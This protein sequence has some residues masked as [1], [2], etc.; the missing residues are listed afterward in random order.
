MAVNWFPDNPNS[1][2]EYV[3]KDVW[4]KCF[5]RM[6]DYECYIKVISISQ[7]NERMLY[8]EIPDFFI[9]EC[10]LEMYTKEE[11]LECLDYTHNDH[12]WDFK[13]VKPYDYATTYEVLN[14]IESC[15]DTP[16]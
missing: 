11:A 15:A 2:W 7:I 1:L 4:V 12:T 9:D 6:G 8:H 5:N 14:C 3:G 16:F 10:I 13:V